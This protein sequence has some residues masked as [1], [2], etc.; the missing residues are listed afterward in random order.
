MS[1]SGQDGRDPTELH[2]KYNYHAHATRIIVLTTAIT[3]K[4]S[5]P[6]NLNQETTMARTNL[7]MVFTIRG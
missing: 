7:R 6:G 1:V 2:N 4:W 3:S 5:S